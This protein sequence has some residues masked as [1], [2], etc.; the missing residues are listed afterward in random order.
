MAQ[1]DAAQ[2]VQRADAGGEERPPKGLEVVE[3]RR[4]KRNAKLGTCQPVARRSPPTS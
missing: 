2:G 4:T 3:R 1:I